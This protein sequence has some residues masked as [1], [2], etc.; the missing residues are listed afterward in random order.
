MNVNYSGNEYQGLLG[1]LYSEIPKTVLAAIAISL[2]SGGGD[3][4]RNARR[5]IAEEW[6]VLH[7]NGIVPQKPG[8]IARAAATKGRP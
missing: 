1:D 6:E 3:F 8:P 7:A 5:K 2:A 4:L